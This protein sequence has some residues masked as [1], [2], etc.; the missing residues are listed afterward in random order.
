MPRH[1]LLAVAVATVLFAAGPVDTVAVA[2]PDLSPRAL[3]PEELDAATIQRAAA[4]FELDTIVYDVLDRTGVPG[5][6]VAVAAAGEVVVAEAYG[7]ADVAAGRPLTLDDPLWLAS[8]T[9]TLTA[10]AALDLVVDGRLDLATPLEQLLPGLVPAP[11]PGDATPLTSWHLLSHTSGFDERNLGSVDAATGPTPPLAALPLPPRVAPAG[12]GPRYGNANYHALGL[13][14]EAVTGTPYAEAMQAL[15]FDPLGLGSATVS[16]PQSEAY[17]AA[18]VP[19]HVR[20]AR[21]ALEPAAALTVRDASAGALRMSGA[22][23]AR[24]LAQLTAA[25]P[26]APLAGDVRTALLSPAARGHPLAAGATTG[27]L[28]SWMLGHEVVVQP[29]D[30]PGSHSLL[31]VVPHAALALFVHVNGPAGDAPTW[32]SADGLRDVRWWLAERLVER[33]VGDARTPPTAV[34][35]ARMPPESRV[36]SGVYRADR[37]ARR[38]PEA[39]LLT[40]GLA[41]LRVDVE[42]D[43]AV[44][45]TPPSVAS[46]P[47]RYLPTEAGVYVRDTGGEVLAVVRDAAGE[48][49][50]HGVLGMPIALER[51][52]TRERLEVAAAS[53]GAAL[54]AALTALVTWPLG[55]LYRRVAR[56]PRSAHPGGSLMLLRFTARALAVGVIAY[57]ALALRALL[58]AQRRLALPDDVWWASASAA[59]ALVVIAAAVLVLVGLSFVVSGG[60]DRRGPALRPRAALHVLLGLSGIALAWQAWVWNLPPWR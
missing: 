14:I 4:R 47:R 12:D 1:A 46:P 60:R 36:E 11:P 17:E 42:A 41:Q 2:Q 27:M 52:P 37:V 15:V 39:F 57:V 26:P 32:A 40:T 20:T 22:D 48:P 3:E 53:F 50:L 7:T 51:V 38:G 24:W 54:L 19:G 56:Q 33:F 31:V 25:E 6:V 34:S 8:I 45:V 18:T 44:V 58:E 21:G 55:S 29:G 35:D 5:I 43:G 9:K 59:L 10:V 49:R 13:V 23:V 16:R 28:E 30:L